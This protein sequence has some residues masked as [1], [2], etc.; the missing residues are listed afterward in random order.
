MVDKRSF[1][2]FMIKD[3]TVSKTRAVVDM[4]ESYLL[5]DTICLVVP[6]QKLTRQKLTILLKK[7]QKLASFNQSQFTHTTPYFTP[8]ETHLIC[9]PM[10]L[11][12]LNLCNCFITGSGGE[13]AQLVRAQG[14]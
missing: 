2:N 13:I 6:Q 14:I 10:C 7:R 3:S 9:R 5:K 4:D 8:P 1:I 12:N 11:R